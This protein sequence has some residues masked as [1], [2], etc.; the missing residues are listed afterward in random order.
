MWIEKFDNCP[1]YWLILSILWMIVIFILSTSLF[2][3]QRT[4]KV[5]DKITTEINFRFIAHLI[6]YFILGFLAS[7]AI[8]LNFSFNNKFLFTMLACC[9]YGVF[10]EFHQYFEPARKFRLIDIITNSG[11]SSL[12]ILSYYLVY[13]RLKGNRN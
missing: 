2:S 5:T 11:G 8:R 13:L 10:D 6:V 4:A 3:P 7:G 12:G 1:K 9:L